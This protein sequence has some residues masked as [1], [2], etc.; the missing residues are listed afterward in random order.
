MDLTKMLET[1]A[2]GDAAARAEVTEKI[3]EAISGEPSEG[4]GEAAE[5]EE[6]PRNEHGQADIKALSDRTFNLIIDEMS[7][8]LAHF[9][10]ATNTLAGAKIVSGA[11]SFALLEFE[12]EVE[13]LKTENLELREQVRLLQR[14]ADQALRFDPHGP[15]ETGEASPGQADPG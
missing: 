7:A 3:V 10:K 15:S 9:T 1:L 5:T 6:D 4:D 2:E 8:G 13:K 12:R 11:T 14:S